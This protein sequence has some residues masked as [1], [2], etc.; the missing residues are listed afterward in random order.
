MSTP[1]GSVRR[2]PT[3]AD[4][5]KLA[6]QLPLQLRSE[7][8]NVIAK[9]RWIDAREM[10]F[11]CVPHV[12]AGRDLIGRLTL[13][14]GN[15]VDLNLRVLEGETPVRSGDG[16]IH[17]ARWIGADEAGRAKVLAA[18]RV[19]N[20]AAF[21]PDYRPSRPPR[22][23]D[24]AAATATKKANAAAALE[25]VR[26][27][28]ADELNQRIVERGNIARRLRLHAAAGLF[29]A[30]GAAWLA[31]SAAEGFQ[32]VRAAVWKFTPTVAVKYDLL[33]G[34][35]LRGLE[36]D[37]PHFAGA[38]LHGA[39]LRGAALRGVDLSGADL[40]AAD[41]RRTDFRGANLSHANLD[42]AQLAG[43]RFAGA[44]LTGASVKT[45][46]G[47]AEFAGALFDTAT[48]WGSAGPVG[49]ALGPGALA[50]GSILNKSVLGAVKLD[51]AQL[52]G[53]QLDGAKLAELS[54][55]GTS[56]KGASFSGVVAT[57]CDF[58]KAD[59]SGAK[60]SD[61]AC[62]GCTLRGARLAGADLSAAKL[63]SADLQA[64]DGSH[65]RLAGATLSSTNVTDAVWPSAN[66]S[67]AKVGNSDFSGANLKG[68]NLMGSNFASAT[69]TEAVLL[70]AVADDQTQ[71]PTG[72][73]PRSAGIIMLSA[74]ITLDKPLLPDGID[75]SGKDLSRIAAVNV[76]AV[77]A[78]FS[79]AKLNESNFS[80]ATLTS[81]NFERAS[82]RSARLSGAKLDNA[83]FGTS[84]L[85]GAILDMASLCGADLS[86]ATLAGTKFR[87]ATACA[88]TKWPGDRTPLGV[89]VH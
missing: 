54:L 55:V 72:F 21:A 73:D 13:S 89:V 60:M 87:G 46:V 43:T 34:I 79:G 14:D 61:F 25:K 83:L 23:Q 27:Q 86:R 53:I 18:L 47:G 26:Q 65:L 77:G 74:G 29:L 11:W 12:P 76:G 64:S 7:T 62:T 22:A 38:N 70:G 85:T 1:D 49:G 20:P 37:T 36:L 16:H 28:Y 17:V 45:D 39:I 57:D 78:N 67:N 24:R 2:L 40:S 35:D 52:D 59:F 15:L 30:L 69:L 41:L 75:L 63:V 31:G 81:A 80:G 19:I 71:W 88:S 3:G 42:G 32:S 8:G 51:G 50:P 10:L 82:L 6:T 44:K 9:V 68:A 5:P 84:D 48:Q 56:F 4:L 33:A 66:L 58:E